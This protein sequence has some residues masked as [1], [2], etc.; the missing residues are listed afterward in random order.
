[1]AA[2]DDRVR[3]LALLAA[4]IVAHLLAIAWF[5]TRVPSDPAVTTRGSGTLIT[6]AP[7]PGERAAP[8]WSKPV[9]RP[10]SAVRAPFPAPIIAMPSL[11]PAAVEDLGATAAVAPGGGGCQLGTA[12]GTAVRGSPTAMGELALLPPGVRTEADAVMI[13]NGSWIAQAAAATANVPPANG[14]MENLRLAIEGVVAAAPDDC[15]DASMTGPVLVPIPDGQRTTMLV[16][17]SGAWRWADLAAVP[18]V[19][20]ASDPRQCPGLASKPRSTN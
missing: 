1:M 9:E 5:L 13:W 4:I 12:V 8:P 3:R 2:A 19:C 14:G 16:I 18:V 17:G 11:L 20:S 6:I 15:R 10:R 7:Q